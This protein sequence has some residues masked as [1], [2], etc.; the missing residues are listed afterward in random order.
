MRS[1]ICNKYI[2][3]LQYALAAYPRLFSFIRQVTRPL[4][5]RSSVCGKDVDERGQK[6][7]VEILGATRPNYNVLF[8]A[9][10][11]FFFFFLRKK[12]NVT[13]TT[14]HKN[15]CRCRVHREERRF[16]ELR[17]LIKLLAFTFFFFLLLFGFVYGSF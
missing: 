9:V 8:T 7:I 17:K 14:D 15:I 6:K 4:P 10:F 1:I 16:P 3:S 5:P 11:F 12:E 2:T 13:K